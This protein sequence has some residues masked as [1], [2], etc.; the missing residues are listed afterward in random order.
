MTQTPILAPCFAVRNSRT[1]PALF[2]NAANRR[3]IHEFLASPEVYWG[4]GRSQA[5]VDRQISSALICFGVFKLPLPEEGNEDEFAEAPSVVAF[6]R[7]VG[8]GERSAYLHISRM[9][10]RFPEYR[11]MGLGKGVIVATLKDSGDPASGDAVSRDS[12]QWKWILFASKAKDI[13]I[14]LG[15]QKTETMYELEPGTLKVT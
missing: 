14:R 5:V 3:V 8:D 7:V 12:T 9:S 10:S 15:F 6:T 11:G 2:R 13:Y 1:S 4:H